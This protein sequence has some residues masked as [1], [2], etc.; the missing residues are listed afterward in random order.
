[1]NII[2]RNEIA[3]VKMTNRSSVGGP[4]SEN[5]EKQSS[6]P[7]EN[8]KFTDRSCAINLGT[9]VGSLESVDPLSNMSNRF[10]EGGKPFVPK[11]S[12]IIEETEASA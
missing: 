8:I 9:N 4:S 11:V 10:E 6:A 2:T 7:G 5:P 3:Y 1:M 12:P